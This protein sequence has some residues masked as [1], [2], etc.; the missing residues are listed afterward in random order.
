MAAADTAVATEAEPSAPRSGLL[1][2]PR[3]TM[4]LLVV[5][6]A[7][8]AGTIAF[9]LLWA[10]DQSA[11]SNASRVQAGSRLV[12]GRFLTDFTT[13]NPSTVA[14]TF[15]DIQSTSTGAFATQ[16]KSEFNAQLRQQLVAADASTQGQVRYLELESSNSHAASF[17]ADVVQTFSNKSTNGPQSDELRLV[18]DLTLVGGHWKVSGV[19]SLDTPSTAGG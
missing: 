19:T 1:V 3:A 11:Q 10:R 8:V 4:V 6:L 12:A 18:V 13:F 15:K 5:A 17:F 14:S 7:G 9:G 16:A 2:N